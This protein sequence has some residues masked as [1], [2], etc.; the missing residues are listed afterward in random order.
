[1]AYENPVYPPIVTTGSTKS[2]DHKEWLKDL[3]DQ[4][5]V[6]Q[7]FLNAIVGGGGIDGVW[8]YG[9]S[10]FE[11][12]KVRA[13]TIP[14]MTVVIQPFAGFVD[15]VPFRIPD[16]LVTSTLSAPISDDRIDV[17]VARASTNSFV[18]IMGVESSS[19]TAPPI[20]DSDV[21]L[22]E[23]YHR[24]GE[25]EILNSDESPNDQGYI[26]DFRTLINA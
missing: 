3:V 21:K 20:Q 24:V 12:G 26:T 19:P 10:P 5:N 15:N 22:A 25:T 8:A 11:V 13:N 1:M 9:P 23:I 14:N 18:V 4:I 17:V 7:W 6:L 2:I 16:Q